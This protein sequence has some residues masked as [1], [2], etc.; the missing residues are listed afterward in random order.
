MTSMVSVE[1][2][3]LAQTVTGVLDALLP[4]SSASVIIHVSAIKICGFETD[5]HGPVSLIK[6][7]C[8]ETNMHGPVAESVKDPL[9]LWSNLSSE[10]RCLIEM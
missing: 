6:I 8:Y 1:M 10:D 4:L 7:C 5:M 9:S 3:C 2:G